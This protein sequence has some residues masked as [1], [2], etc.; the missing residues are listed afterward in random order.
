MINFDQFIAKYNG[1]YLDWDGH[2]GPQCVDLVRFFIDEVLGFPQT[3]MPAA[4][5]AKQIYQ[6]FKSNQYF[7]KIGNTPTGVPTKGD[8][9]FWGYPMGFYWDGLVPK[10]AGDV[11]IFSGG[12]VIKFIS[13]G[14][15]FPKGSFCRYY[16]HSYKGVMGWLHRK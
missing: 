2:Y 4:G 8:I 14:Q 13:F 15:N 10:W 9:V 3:S 12:G 7:D 5:T 11:A 6:N 1:K 16:N